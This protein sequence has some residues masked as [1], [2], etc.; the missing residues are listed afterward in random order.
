MSIKVDIQPKSDRELALCRIIDAPREKVYRAWTDPELL[1]QWFCPKPWRVSRAD[2]DVRPGGSSFVLM[3][4]P[5]GEE[6]P[7]PGVY[8]EVIPNEK[9]VFTDAYTN[10]WEPN[11]K[12]FMT[13]VIT[14]EDLNGKTKYTARVFHWSVEDKKQHEAMGFH[15]GWSICADQ[16]EELL[17]K[18]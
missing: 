5:N 16:L 9:L 8:L 7:N 12:P 6:F 15:E 3:N 11:A 1:K 17:T 10:A 14:F 18:H 4:G 2:L 13:A